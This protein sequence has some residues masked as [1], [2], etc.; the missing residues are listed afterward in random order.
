MGCDI[1]CVI[2]RK[3]EGDMR[4]VGI[5]SSDNMK[6]RPTYAQRD[7]GFFGELA[8]VRDKSSKNRYPQNLPEDVS[9]LSWQEYMQS[10]TDHHSASHLPLSEFCQAWVDCNNSR[11]EA[12][13]NTRIRSDHAVYD[14][15]GVDTDYPENTV[16]RV[17]FWFDN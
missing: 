4:W 17:V 6:D 13:R 3:R 14:L 5:Q 7:Y 9:D 1:H 16:Y 15:T 11:D 12:Y 2:E 8:S 10:P